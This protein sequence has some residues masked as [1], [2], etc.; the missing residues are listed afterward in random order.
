MKDSTGVL[1]GRPEA[2]SSKS[3]PT[4]VPEYRTGTESRLWPTAH[5]LLPRIILV[6]ARTIV[7]TLSSLAILAGLFDI[8]L[9]FFDLIPRQPT[10]GILFFLRIG[11]TLMVGIPVILTQVLIKTPQPQRARRAEIIGLIIVLAVGLVLSMLLL[12][13]MYVGSSWDG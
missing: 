8:S 11:A 9:Y 7:Y 13:Q 12:P 3:N 10:K 4:K 2:F 1:S 5:F 6:Q